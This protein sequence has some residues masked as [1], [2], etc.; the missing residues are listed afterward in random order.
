MVDTIIHYQK[1][2][3]NTFAGNSLKYLYYFLYNT[4]RERKKQKLNAEF[5]M[6]FARNKEFE[7]IK[8]MLSLSSLLPS[9]NREGDRS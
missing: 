1:Q 5:G 6:S 9:G 3:V 7:I 8:V 4:T 2:L